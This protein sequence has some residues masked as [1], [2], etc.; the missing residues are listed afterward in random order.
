MQKDTFAAHRSFCN[1]APRRESAE[2]TP[3]EADLNVSSGSI[4]LGLSGVATQIHGLAD[5]AGQSSLAAAAAA[6]QF[7]H[8]M[9]SSSSGPSM[10]RSQAP[11]SSSFLLGGKAPSPAQDFS[12]DGD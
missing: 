1:M 7:D 3:V 10:L 9:P 5:Q 2:V 11:S 8:I 4:S 6:V 12:E